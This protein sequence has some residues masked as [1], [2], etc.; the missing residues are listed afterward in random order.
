MKKTKKKDSDAYAERKAPED[1]WSLPDGHHL[2]SWCGFDKNGDAVFPASTHTAPMDEIRIER[3]ALQEFID[4][5][6]SHVHRQYRVIAAKEQAWWESVEKDYGIKRGSGVS[7]FY[8]DRCF[9]KVEEQK[10]DV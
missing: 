7:Y 3:Q 9:K 5:M 10:A 6:Q 8:N 4:A 1:I 2:G